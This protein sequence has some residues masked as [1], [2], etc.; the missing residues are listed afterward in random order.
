MYPSKASRQMTE[1]ANHAAK[2][3]CGA[4]GCPL[5]GSISPYFGS[6]I[7]YFCRHHHGANPKDWAKITEDVR[8]GIL[9]ADNKTTEEMNTEAQDWMRSKGVTGE[10]GS[11]EWKEGRAAL[12]AELMSKKEPSRDWA[13]QIVEDW[14]DGA[15]T[16]R[17]GY[18]LA[19]KALRVEIE[20]EV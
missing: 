4:R 3:Q 8:R 17:Y 16:S 19:C 14:N 1:E 5:A 15:Y 10:V 2:A 11:Q 12:I 6:G 20:V 13:K 9:T 7:Q 18:E